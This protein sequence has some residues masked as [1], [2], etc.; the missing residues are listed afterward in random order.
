M[1]LRSHV[2]RAK[3]YVVTDKGDSDYFD[4]D[5]DYEAMKK[6]WLEKGRQKFYVFRRES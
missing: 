5:E 4:S 6:I 1:T 2:R 3:L